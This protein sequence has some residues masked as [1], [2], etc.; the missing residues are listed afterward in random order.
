M[1]EQTLNL[2]KQQRTVQPSPVDI[3]QSVA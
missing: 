1:F 2:D 3:E